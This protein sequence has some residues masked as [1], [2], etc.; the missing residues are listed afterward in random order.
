ME[1]QKPKEQETKKT[2]KK[3]EFF[4]AKYENLLKILKP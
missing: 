4:L 2:K 3:V 1:N